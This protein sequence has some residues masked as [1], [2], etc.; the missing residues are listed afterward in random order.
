MKNTYAEPTV[1]IIALANEDIVT[2]SPGD[3]ETKK[4]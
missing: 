2:A 1:E 4:F 3:N